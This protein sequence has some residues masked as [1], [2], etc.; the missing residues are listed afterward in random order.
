MNFAAFSTLFLLAS[1][2]AATPVNHLNGK[3]ERSPPSSSFASLDNISAGFTIPS[4][5][6]APP[7]TSADT[8][9]FTQS[10]ASVSHVPFG[11]LTESSGDNVDKEGVKPEQNQGLLLP[12][13]QQ[14]LVPRRPPLLLIIW[15]QPPLNLHLP[16]VESPTKPPSPSTFSLSFGPYFFSTA[17]TLTNLIP[18]PFHLFISFIPLT[19]V[20]YGLGDENNSPN[21]NDASVSCGF[22]NDPGYNAAAS[23]NLYGAASGKTDTCG[24]CWQLNPVSNP[25]AANPNATVAGLNSIVVK[26]NNLCPIQGNEQDVSQNPVLLPCNQRVESTY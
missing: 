1:T 23:Q 16:A 11:F 17:P 24:T 8:V 22:Y 7:A 26:V 19:S 2:V 3:W 6:D 20:R 5:T 10:T 13:R 14:T 18:I 25:N 15:P 12:Q 9:P 21:C 4:G